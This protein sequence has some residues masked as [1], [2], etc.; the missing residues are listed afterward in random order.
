MDRRI[1]LVGPQALFNPS[2]TPFNIRQMCRAMVDLGFRVELLSFPHG[3]DEPMDGVD[4]RRIRSLPGI[5]RVPPGLSP[6]KLIYDGLLA[7]EVFLRARAS[8]YV[9]I[10]AVEEAAFFCAPIARLAKIPLVVDLDSDLA[11]QLRDHSTVAAT[12]AAPARALRRYALRCTACAITVAPHLTDLVRREAP[13][14]PVFE[15][16][17]TPLPEALQLPDP[18]AVDGF[19]RKWN[20]E[21]RPLI[22][23]TGNFDRRQGLDL[24]VESWVKLAARHPSA[25]LLLVGGDDV[26]RD[27]LGRAVAA[28]GAED[29]VRFAG[30]HPPEAM[31][32]F[33]AIADVLV[34][35]RL[36]PYVTP[37]KI[38]SYMASGRP[39][40]A[41]DLPT[42]RAVL[43]ET[44]AVLVPPTVDG[45]ASGLARAL[46]G[47]LTETGRRARERVL[48]EYGFP[49]FRA[50]L[51]AVYDHVGRI[52]AGPATMPSCRPLDYERGA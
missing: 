48:S 7:V 32:L 6:Q 16:P 24:L 42:H 10:H 13:E 12:L 35:P 33:M 49:R 51:A 39:I 52:A 27:R 40:V 26:S 36:E 9:A 18:R 19:R 3:A 15:I 43:D 28:N 45:L 34:S 21:G 41:T 37:L 38:Y 29:S 30:A 17:D 25:S 31:P 22:V 14:V 11:A 47:D 20:P 8:R 50:R 46:D 44:T 5:S 1:L 23:Y 4:H 2:G